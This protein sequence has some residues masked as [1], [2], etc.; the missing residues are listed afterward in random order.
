MLGVH[1]FIEKKDG[2]FLFH[3][4]Y[5]WIYK[6]MVKNQFGNFS[7]MGSFRLRGGAQASLLHSTW[8]RGQLTYVLCP[9]LIFCPPP[10]FFI[11]NLF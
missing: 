2:L 11:R 5:F 4:L 6:K 10:F 8:A 9:S 1:I 3:G 7:L